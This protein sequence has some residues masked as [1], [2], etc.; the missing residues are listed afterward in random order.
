MAALAACLDRQAPPAGSPTDSLFEAGQALYGD[1]QFDSAHKVWTIALGRARDSSDQQ[2]EARL[3]TELG[4]AEWR[5]TRIAQAR[6]TQEAAIALKT[7]LGLT[8]ELSRS[9]NALGLVAHSEGRN[10]EAVRAFSQAADAARAA[11]DSLAL[12][13][14]LG[15]QALPTRNLGDFAAAREAARGLRAAGGSMGDVRMEANGLSNE[16]MVDLDI[17]DARSAIRRLD[18]ARQLYGRIVY[19]TGEQVAL[20]QQASAWE[21][22]GDYDRSFAALD[23]ALASL[24]DSGTS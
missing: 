15:N 10:H 17:G 23:T 14:A 9:Y 11:G 19:R 5:L 6:A 20:G 18:T 16:A 22:T 21:L 8:A 13:K 3:L 7:A 24:E 2:K 4:I 1:E 12:S